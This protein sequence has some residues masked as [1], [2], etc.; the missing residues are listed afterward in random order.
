MIVRLFRVADRFVKVTPEP[1][2]RGV[3]RGIGRVLGFSHIRGARQLRAN[4]QRIVPLGSVWAE[5]VRSARAMRSYLDYYYEVFALPYLRPEQ[6]DARFRAV[7]A[8]KLIAH[9]ETGRSCSAALLH[10]GNWDL[11]GAWANRNLA[12]VHSIAEKLPVA[13]LARMFLDFRRSLGMTIYPTGGGAMRGLLSDMAAGT[14]FVPLLC[15]RDL[16]ASGVEV[17][18]CGHQARI[19]VG[20]A[21]LAQRSGQPMFPVTIVNEDFRADRSRVAQAGGHYGGCAIIGEPIYPGVGPQASEQEREADL[22]RMN[23]E[24][25][26]QITPLLIAHVTDWHMLQKVF[27]DDLD[28]QRLARARMTSR[29]EL[30]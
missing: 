25:M 12:P 27:V 23:Q 16:S 19:A 17:N 29:K 2:A 21:L 18:I 11:A 13:E 26:D 28:P 7:D 3:F 30:A 14:A 5:H 10:L 6:I 24:W 9:L 4:L 8:T 20:A 22:I 1:I 15:D